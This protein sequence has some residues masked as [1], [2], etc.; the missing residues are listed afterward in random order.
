[1]FVIVRLIG[2]T[3][4]V[5][6]DLAFRALLLANVT[7]TLGTALVSPLLSTLTGPLGVSET[8]IGL[9]ITAFSAPA[10]V[11][12]PL[13]GILAD[14]VGRKPL[15]VV[16]LIVY[17]I[18]GA[19][20]GLTTDFRIVLFLRFIQGCG[21]SLV[22]PTI[23]A[24]VG[25]LYEGVTEATAQGLRFA[26]SGFSQMAFPLVAGLL[27]A[28]AWQ[29]PFALYAV[30][31][32]V[33]VLVY[34]WFD[35]PTQSENSSV[36][37]SSGGQRLLRTYLARPSVAALLVARGLPEFLFIGFLTFISMIVV[38]V[39]NYSPREAGLLVAV[40]SL[41]YALAAT[42]TGRLTTVFDNRL[43]LMVLGTA[44]M[45]AGLL[46]VAFAPSLLALVV[47]IAVF[48]VAYGVL[49]TLYRSTI[50]RIGSIEVR[51]G[52]VSVGE[53]IGRVFATFVPI[54]VGSLVS[55]GKPRLGYEGA[56]RGMILVLVAGATILGFGCLLFIR[57]LGEPL[58][59]T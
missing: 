47:G 41:V 8:Q 33:S 40:C 21:Y 14:R 30:A 24:S 26:T 52:L 49:I 37:S 25:D 38:Q 54:V 6:D 36:G 16:G 44:G 59:D 58:E 7:A 9:I 27:V 13:A 50:A 11:C 31:I 51:G 46:I 48:A 56:I 42:Q 4:S 17:G 39:L 57:S 32:P 53:S 34:F 2:D 12:I 19:A 43:P 18:T 23:V 29:Y 28:F 1:M 45:G 15:L 3:K 35:E 5:I 22:L 10:I 55:L 20:V